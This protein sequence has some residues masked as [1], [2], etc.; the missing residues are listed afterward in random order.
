MKPAKSTVLIAALLCGTLLATACVT[1]APHSHGYGYTYSHYG[2][3]LRYDNHLG[4]YI[5]VGMPH[6]YFYHDRYYRY[7]DD[8]WYSSAELNGGWRHY[9]Q[10]RLPPGLAKKY[11]YE[12]KR[13]RHS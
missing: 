5:V 10:R 8:R 4:V 12:S 2:H 9:D 11:G 6:H 3:D 7:Y 13:R 1:H